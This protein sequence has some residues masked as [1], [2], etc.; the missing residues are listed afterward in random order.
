MHVWTTVRGQTVSTASGRPLQPVAD[1]HQDILNSAIFEL[2]EDLQPVLGA[3]TTVTGPDPENVPGALD[4]DGHRNI[5]RAVG[6][7]AI[8]NLDVDGVHEDDRVNAVQRAGLPFHHA[9]HHLVRD[10]GDGLL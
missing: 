3:L 5:D 7:L 9:L 4:R 8:A 6:D 2:G 10:R 1:E